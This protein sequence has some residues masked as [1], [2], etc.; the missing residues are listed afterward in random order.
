MHTKIIWFDGEL[1]ITAY[2]KNQTTLSEQNQPTEE[3]DIPASVYSIM[4]SCYLETGN[5]QQAKQMIS[6]LETGGVEIDASVYSSFITTLGFGGERA[7]GA[8]KVEGT[9]KTEAVG[10][11]LQM[12]DH[13]K[14]RGHEPDTNTY[15]QLINNLINLHQP[16]KAFQLLISLVNSNKMTKDAISD[17]FSPLVRAYCSNEDADNAL[18]VVGLMK[19]VNVAPNEFLVTALVF[20]L[21]R[22]KQFNQ[23]WDV[24]AWAKNC[25]LDTNGFSDVIQTAQK[26][27]T[28]AQ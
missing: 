10:E 17:V 23:A 16:D 21:V 22:G 12:V 13:M 18:K 6:E 4:L 20:C 5:Y 8:E 26:K 15:R 14:A 25:G 3:T 7:D 1:Q 28:L 11:V 27:I 2:Y 19:K 24:V 9:K